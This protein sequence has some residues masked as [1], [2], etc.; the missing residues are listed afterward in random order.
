MKYNDGYV[1]DV[2]KDHGRSPKG[3]GYGNEF[4]RMVIKERPGYYDV[5]WREK[6]ETNTAEP[7]KQ[8]QGSK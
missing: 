4:F 8:T 6:S 7:N 1:N 2:T 5:R 3:V